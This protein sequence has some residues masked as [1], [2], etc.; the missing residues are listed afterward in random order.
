MMQIA[1]VYA[2]DVI[3]LGGGVIE[4]DQNLLLAAREMFITLRG[5]LSPPGLEIVG[6]P[7]PSDEAG[8]IG[9]ALLA[10]EQSRRSSSGVQT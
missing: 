8:V 10:L 3:A 4:G 6:A 5:S 1:N 2:P 9:A 7:L